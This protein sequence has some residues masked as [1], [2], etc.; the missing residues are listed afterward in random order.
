[1]KRF[2]TNAM[3][4]LVAVLL[5]VVLFYF[6]ENPNLFSASILSLQDSETMKANSWDIWYKN[7]SKILDVFLAEWIKDINFV[8]LSVIYD[9]QDVFF[10][11][12]KIDSQTKYEV[13]S[14][15]WW[16]LVLK[17]TDFSNYNYQKSLFELPFNGK[18]PSI[19]LSE[20]A[21]MSLNWENKNLS[22]WFLNQNSDQ[23]HWF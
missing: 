3:I 22:I 2:R 12:Q 19:L 10:D 6:T 23:Y 18:L 21:I 15:E 20:W 8:S 11:L 9:E 16:I 7:E 5:S 13:L 17:F 14:N 4:F 1:M